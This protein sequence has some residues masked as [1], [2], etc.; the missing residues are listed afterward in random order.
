MPRIKGQVR[1]EH[2]HRYAVC[3]GIVKDKTVLDIA[4]G[5]G[6][7]SA[8]LGRTAKQVTGVDIDEQSVAHARDK[9]SHIGNLRYIQGSVDAIP[10]ATDSVDV[11]VS[12][13]TIEHVAGHEEMLAELKRVLK[14]DGVLVISTPDKA[15]YAAVSAN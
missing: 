5:E 1:Y 4:C 15:A 11:V 13:E 8:I 3:Q 12:F 6:Y 9:Y 10:L 14:A 7:G 2:I